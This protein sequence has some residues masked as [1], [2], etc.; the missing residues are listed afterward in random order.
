MPR[1][2]SMAE[3]KLKDLR[4]N[5][6]NTILLYFKNNIERNNIKTRL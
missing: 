4:T 1:L 5:F 2:T 6:E 3:H